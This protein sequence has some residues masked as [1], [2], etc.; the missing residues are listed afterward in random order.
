MN[1][2]I[3]TALLTTILILCGT[4]VLL[5]FKYKNI[6]ALPADKVEILSSKLTGTGK[7]ILAEEKVYHEYTKE[8]KKG[9]ARAKVLFRWVMTLQYM[10]DFENPQFRITHN[11][12][13]LKINSPAITMNE[14]IIDITFY[15]PAIVIDGSIWLNEEKLINDEMQHFKYL[16][17]IA[18]K[19]LLENPQVQKLC[20]DQ[21]KLAVL[22]ISSG[23]QI[24]VDDIDVE[25]DGSKKL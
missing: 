19:D 1:R 8:F 11:R 13:N 15:K 22:K 12:N 18:G 17:F 4:I 5:W 14:P 2:I 23:L 20:T 9:P 24:Q 3:I 21:L 16:S 25:F 6:T 7:L 10:V